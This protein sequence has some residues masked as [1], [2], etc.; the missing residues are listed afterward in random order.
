MG[1]L[2]LKHEQVLWEWQAQVRIMQGFG[3][4]GGGTG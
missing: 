4:P 3:V 1:W 2:G